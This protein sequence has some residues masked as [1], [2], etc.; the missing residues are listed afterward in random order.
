MAGNSREC[1]LA[2]E[3][4]N[5]VRIDESIT[6]LTGMRRD[7]TLRRHQ[8]RVQNLTARIA[9]LHPGTIQTERDMLQRRLHLQQGIIQHYQGSS[10]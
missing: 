8:L 4:Q 9:S 5:G 1:D 2:Q 6:R 7:E 10:A 3:I